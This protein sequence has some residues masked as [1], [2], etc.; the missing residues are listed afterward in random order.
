MI[1]HLCAGVKVFSVNWLVVGSRDLIR[2]KSD[3][4]GQDYCMIVWS[5][6]RT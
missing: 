2:L 5:S 6:F 3:F 1:L 4:E